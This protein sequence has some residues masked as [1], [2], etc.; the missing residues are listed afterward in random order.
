[1]KTKIPVKRLQINKAQ[2]RLLMVIAIATILSVFF[3]VSTKTLLSQAAYQKR[4]IDTRRDAVKQLQ[5]NVKSANSLVQNYEQVFEGTSPTNLIGGRRDPAPNA[6]PPNGTNARVVLNAL[7]SSYDF[8]ALITSVTKILNDNAISS[9]SISG[10]DESVTLVTDPEAE[11]QPQTVKLNV[12]GSGSYGNVQKLVTDL[13]RSIR[14]FNIS[15]LQIRGSDS[16]MFITMNVDTYFQPSKT[17]TI[18][19]KEVK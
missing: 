2:S 18:G 13:E 11:P 12:G 15:N 10:T 6:T 19:T 17:L 5:E 4:L 9:P 3:L 8:P 1:M 14:P 7:P 16:Q